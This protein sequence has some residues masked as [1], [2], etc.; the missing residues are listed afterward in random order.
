M[1]I[2][3]LHPLV[4]P[5]VS[6]NE[7]PLQQIIYK[8]LFHSILK[9]IDTESKSLMHWNASLLMSLSPAAEDGIY[10]EKLIAHV[11][12]EQPAGP[13]NKVTVVGVGMVGM[14]AAISV[15][16]K[17][18]ESLHFINSHNRTPDQSCYHITAYSSHALPLN[19]FKINFINYLY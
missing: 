15:L 17:V 5:S 4:D 3:S 18:S 2:K 6:W 13:T 10:K 8:M 16:L 19:M 11:S 9:S 12:K 1:K 14:A 7:Q